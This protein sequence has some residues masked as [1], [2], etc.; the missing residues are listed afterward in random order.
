[1]EAALMVARPF[2]RFALCGM[3]SQYN[4]T[5]MGAGVRGLIMI[6]GKQLRLEGFIVSSHVD[7]QAAFI[8]DMTGWIAN[9]KVKWRETVEEGIENA[10]TAFLKLFKGENL[11]KMLVRLS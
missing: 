5:D 10:P 11:G 2:A 3:I 7:M 9:G 8:K 1:M 6:V 4:A